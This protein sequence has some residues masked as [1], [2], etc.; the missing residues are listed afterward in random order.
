[1]PW[2]AIKSLNGIFC[3]TGCT[4]FKVCTS[5][6]SMSVAVQKFL[7]QGFPE[8]S[9]ANFGGSRQ[10]FSKAGK[11]R[12]RF[13][14][15]GGKT[16]SN[17]AV[18]SPF[19]EPRCREPPKLI[20]VCPRRKHHTGTIINALVWSKSRGVQKL[21]SGNPGAADCYVSPCVVGVCNYFGSVLV[22][23][24]DDVALKVLLEEIS[25]EHSLS[26][27]GSSVSEA[28]RRA[29]L[30]VNV[31]DYAGAVLAVE[32]VVP[33][34]VETYEL[35]VCSNFN[36]NKT[37]LYISFW[38]NNTLHSNFCHGEFKTNPLSTLLNIINGLSAVSMLE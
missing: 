30:V 21:V 6:R 14:S 4:G 8:M 25:V 36:N 7:P 9:E 32:V 28:Y 22:P 34:I 16:S 2:R 12:K 24:A 26:V 18:L 15:E 38:S 10:A 11:E 17:A 5:W 37:A 35:F 31:T 20:F 13:V 27:W 1:M 29:V 23:D 3:K 33:V 19:G